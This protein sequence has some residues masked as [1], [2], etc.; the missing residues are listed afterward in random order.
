MLWDPL[1]N[2]NKF[3]DAL[4]K[5]YCLRWDPGSAKSKQPFLLA[6]IVYATEALDTAE[7]PRR[8]EAEI[9]TML[10]KIPQWI[11]TIQDTKNTFSTRS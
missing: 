9:T 3:I 1:Q 5:M 7:P 10:H 4:Q 11:Q 6:S 2:T 8:N